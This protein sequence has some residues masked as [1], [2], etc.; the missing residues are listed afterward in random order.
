MIGACRG[1]GGTEEGEGRVVVGEAGVVG[2]ERS[3]DG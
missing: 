1:V 3:R 2:G